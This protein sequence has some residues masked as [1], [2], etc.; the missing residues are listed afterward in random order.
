ME[1]ENNLIDSANQ[2]AKRLEDANKIMEA[3]IKKQEALEARRLLGGEADA[4]NKPPEISPEDKLKVD[5]KNYFK[6]T[7][8]EGAFR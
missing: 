5:T 7:A 8:I 4:G 2:A 3:L 6:G 1:T